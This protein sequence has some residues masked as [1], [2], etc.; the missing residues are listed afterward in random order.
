MSA[1]EPG[2]SISAKGFLLS[3]QL[4]V[5]SRTTF[6]RVVVGISFVTTLGTVVACS[7]AS[8]PVRVPPPPDLRVLTLEQFRRLRTSYIARHFCTTHPPITSPSGIQGRSTTTGATIGGSRRSDCLRQHSW[9][10]S[11]QRCPAEDWVLR[12]RLRLRMRTR[13]DACDS[14]LDNEV[15]CPGFVS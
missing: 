1:V 14:T 12:R 7:D 15:V 9:N 13:H 6:A 4:R 2:Q 11:P 8:S 3:T 5:V 10:E